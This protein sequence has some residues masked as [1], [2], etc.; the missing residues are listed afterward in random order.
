MA[1]GCVSY[2]NS[3]FLPENEGYERDGD[4]EDVEQVEAGAAE[5]S[6]VQDEPVGHQLHAHLHREDAR[7]EVVKVVQHLKSIDHLVLFSFE[8]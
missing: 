8:S 2:F 6:L 1:R 5:G 3:G 7:E 4:D